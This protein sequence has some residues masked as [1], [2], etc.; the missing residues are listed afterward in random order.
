MLY[1]IRWFP[2]HLMHSCDV[3][4]QVSTFAKYLHMLFHPPVFLPVSKRDAVVLGRGYDM[5][6]HGALAISY[7]S[8]DPGFSEFGYTGKYPSFA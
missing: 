3:P 8:K 2:N 7:E 1:Y 4:Q 6:E 5:T